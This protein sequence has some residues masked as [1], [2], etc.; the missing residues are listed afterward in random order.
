[1]AVGVDTESLL[2]PLT[3]GDSSGHSAPNPPL[4]QAAGRY[5][6]FTLARCVFIDNTLKV[7]FDL[8]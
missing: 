5:L 8:I 2:R 3:V 7:A 1:M 4:R 6:P